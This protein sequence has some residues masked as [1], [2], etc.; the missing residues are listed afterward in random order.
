[1]YAWLAN[2]CFKLIGCVSIPNEGFT[3]LLWVLCFAL[4]AK[5]EPQWRKNNH[6]MHQGKVNFG[7]FPGGS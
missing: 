4:G 7:R 1:M 3:G 2:N 6:G 5:P